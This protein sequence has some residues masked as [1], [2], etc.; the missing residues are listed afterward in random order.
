ML[1]YLDSLFDDSRS[2]LMAS[3]ELTQNSNILT[4]LFSDLSI[5]LHRQRTLNL[6]TIV[7]VL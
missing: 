3:S 6:Q 4:D 5:L 2:H 7:L 1:L